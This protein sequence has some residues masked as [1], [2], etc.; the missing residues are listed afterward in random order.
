MDN[1]ARERSQSPEPIVV[2]KSK[3]F[4][5][6]QNFGATVVAY[7]EGAQNKNVLGSSAEEV[8]GKLIREL[9][10]NTDISYSDSLSDYELGARILEASRSGLA[11]FEI[12][13]INS[14]L[15]A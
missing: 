9:G 14:D 13:T 5:A 4:I 1:T 8:L 6:S 12:Q 2:N 3:I 7:T 10:A 11:P 15:M